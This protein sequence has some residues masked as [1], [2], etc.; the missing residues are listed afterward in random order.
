MGDFGRDLEEHPGREDLERE[1]E[2]ER[3]YGGMEEKCC[4]WLVV[5]RVRA[6]PLAMFIYFITSM[7]FYHNN[8]SND[9]KGDNK[10][11]CPMMM[12]I[13]IIIKQQQQQ[14]MGAH[15]QIC[16]FIILLLSFF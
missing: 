6:V 10:C 1:R 4:L 9:N 13:I 16:F 3:I 2:R 7:R 11:G 15:T 12:M 5:V 8:N 14:M